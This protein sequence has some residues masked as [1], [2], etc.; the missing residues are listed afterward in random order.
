VNL[1]SSSSKMLRVQA[2]TP[3]QSVEMTGTTEHHSL[4]PDVATVV[5]LALARCGMSHKEACLTHISLQRLALLP[6][7]FW[8]EFIALLAD[9]LHLTVAHQDM[10]DAALLRIVDLVDSFAKVFVQARAERRV[11]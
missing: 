2:T 8:R 4:V 7:T 10:T 5:N 11:A 1:P 3:H 9:P 6:P